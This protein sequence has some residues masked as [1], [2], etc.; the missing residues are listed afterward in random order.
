MN[1]YID[2][3][4]R[5]SDCRSRWVGRYMEVTHVTARLEIGKNISLSLHTDFA[6][7]KWIPTRWMVSQMYDGH[8]YKVKERLVGT[9]DNLEIA[10]VSERNRARW[11]ETALWFYG[12]Q[13]INPWWRP[14][15][16]VR[17]V[18]EA[19]DFY[20]IQLPNTAYTDTLFKGV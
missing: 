13:F 11:W 16:C 6:E 2:G 9:V 1:F 14:Q 15:G 17:N 4:R 18:R 3:W 10:P 5:D 8:Y 7:A 20:G 19:A 12:G